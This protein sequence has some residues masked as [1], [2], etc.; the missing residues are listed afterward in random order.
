MVQYISY[1]FVIS[2]CLVEYIEN[3]LLLKKNNAEGGKVGQPWLGISRTVV[4]TGS[5]TSCGIT[6][7]GRVLLDKL[8]VTHLFKKFS[9]CYAIRSFISVFT[10]GCNCAFC[11]G[12]WNQFTLILYLLESPFKYYTTVFMLLS[13]GFS[14]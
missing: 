13:F 9:G 3:H 12:S 8:T 10:I 14:N 7:W 6:P 11:W 1:L 4:N 5:C 2:V